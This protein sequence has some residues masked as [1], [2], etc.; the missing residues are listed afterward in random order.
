MSFALIGQLLTTVISFASRTVF[1]R[2][3]GKEYL[4]VAGLFGNILSILTLAEFGIGAAIVYSLYKPLAENNVNKIQALMKLFKKT[5]TCVG[6]FI[7]VAGLALTP[8]LD[9]FVSDIPNIPNF[10]LIY[11]L[12]VV[13]NASAYFFSYK[14]MLINADQ[15]QYLTTTIQH[16]ASFAMN[17]AQIIILLVTH[18]YILYL[19]TMIAF[20]F[21]RNIAI[22]ILADKMYPYLK[23]KNDAKLEKDEKESIINNVKAMIMHKVGGIVVDSTDNILLSKLV[24]IAVVGMYSNYCLITHT[25]STIYNLLFNALVSSVGNLGV[26]EDKNKLYDNFKFI[27]FAG[28]WIYTFSFVCLLNLLNPFVKVWLGE[29]Y[30]FS[31]PMV[32]VISMNFYLTGMRNSVLTFRSA[33][34]L[35]WY[36]RYK[37]FGEAIVNLIVSIVLGIKLGAIGIFIGTAF[38]TITLCITVEPYITFKYGFNR[39]AKNYYTQYIKNLIIALVLAFGIGVVGLMLPKQMYV[40]LIMKMVLCFIVPNLVLV[41]LYRKSPEYNKMI[42]VLKKKVLRIEK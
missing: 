10:E 37:A 40:N 19:F 1:V 14:G 5:Y 4:G 2:V 6:L 13:N 34:G 18:N 28:T 11:V 16:T 27:D 36:D 38:S 3:L 15:K 23:D 17:L 12:Y 26:A 32:F 24:N 21:A 31:Q 30:L 7:L 29:D 35:F 25:L 22:S 8:R 20:T 41:L 42:S 9:L 33:L 39:S